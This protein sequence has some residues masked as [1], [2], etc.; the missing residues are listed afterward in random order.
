MTSGGILVSLCA[1]VFLSVVGS[2]F[3]HISQER[4]AQL[5][6]KIRQR[7]LTARQLSEA[8][9]AIEPWSTLRSIPAELAGMAIRSW[10]EVLM[11]DPQSTQAQTEL[12]SI[13]TLARSLSAGKQVQPGPI[14]LATAQEIST[15]QRHLHNAESIFR[16]LLERGSLDKATFRAYANELKWLALKAE[17]DSLLHQGTLAQERNDKVRFMGFCQRALNQVKKS[18]LQDSRKTDYIKMISDKLA[19]RDAPRPALGMPL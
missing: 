5:A 11:L 1:L 16:C 4:R 6:Q 9:H 2:A 8:A 12:A 3:A 17:V 15:L 7:Q 14:N 10:R 13:E 18:Q 19:E